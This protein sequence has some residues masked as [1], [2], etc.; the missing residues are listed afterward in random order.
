VTYAGYL[1]G[2]ADI[3]ATN[4]DL[5]YAYGGADLEV[6]GTVTDSV[7]D[8]AGSGY[9]YDVGASVTI[10]DK[11]SFQDEQF[12]RMTFEA[13]RA[14]NW[15]ETKMKNSPYKPFR[16]DVTFKNSY[17]SF[18]RNAVVPPAPFQH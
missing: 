8:K 17:D 9:R 15:L 4:N 3:V 11:Y 18:T 10:K 12:P 6:N 16:T 14:A 2:V 7:K 1:V 13:Y 5:F